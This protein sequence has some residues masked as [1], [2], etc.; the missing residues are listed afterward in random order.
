MLPK[1]SELLVLEDHPNVDACCIRVRLGPDAAEAETCVNLPASRSYTIGA[2]FRAVAANECYVGFDEHVGP[3]CGAPN[4]FFSASAPIAVNSVAFQ[5]FSV[6][7][8]VAAEVVSIELVLLCTRTDQGSTEFLVDDVF[9]T[10]GAPS[11]TIF[12]NGF[13]T[14]PPAR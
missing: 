1:V 9:V 2:S 5:R 13:E 11:L 12:P 14:P 7:K 3:N 6:A 10:A 8:T 4:G